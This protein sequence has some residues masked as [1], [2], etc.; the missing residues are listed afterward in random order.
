MH[1]ITYITAAYEVE[2][3]LSMVLPTQTE[4]FQGYVVRLPFNASEVYNIL[5]KVF[6][7]CL[8]PRALC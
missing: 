3:D 1:T 6:L 2:D 7:A 8:C 5:M 4:P